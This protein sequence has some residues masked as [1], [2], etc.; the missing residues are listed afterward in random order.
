[1]RLTDLLALSNVP[2]WSIISITAPQNVADHTFRTMAI[3]VE[4]ALRTGTILTAGDMLRILCHDGHESW[5]ADMPSPLKKD[6]EGAGVNFNRMVPWVKSLPAWSSPDAEHAFE[7][8]DKIEA[9]T[10]IY[11]WGVGAQA[12][13]ITEGCRRTVSELVSNTHP[14]WKGAIDSVVVDIIQESERGWT[15]KRD[16]A[17]IDRRP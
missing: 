5:T 11:K 3:A 14:H 10:F 16:Q 15:Y 8:A 9:Y 6:I 13:R 1:M 4:V 2:R 17:D 7:L 12:E